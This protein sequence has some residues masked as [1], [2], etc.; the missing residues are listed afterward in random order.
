MTIK[1]DESVISIIDDIFDAAEFQLSDILPSEWAEQNRFM[2]SD[3]S[4]MEGMFSFDNSPYTRE[5]VDFY[6]PSNPF[7][8]LAIMKGAQVGFSTSVLENAIGWIISQQ[9]GNILFLVGHDDLVEKA[10]KKVD[11]ML[12][13]SGIRHLIHDTSGR[14]KKNKSGDKDR[15]K[16]FTGGFLTLGPTNH[17]TLR[18]VSIKYALIDD[19]EAMK[20]DT[21]ESGGTV[22]MIK[23]RL[24]SY[25]NSYK[26]T[27]LSTPE[28][29]ETSNIEPEYLKGD[30][31]KYFIPCPCCGESI[32]L[33]WE[34]DSEI[35]DGEK[36]GMYWELNENTQLVTDSVGYVCQKCDGFFTDRN[37]SE[38][39]LNGEWKATAI[40]TD[41]EYTSYHLSALMAPSYMFGWT[42]Y[43]K[44][45]LEANPPGQPRN[46]KLHQA[47]V[48]LVLGQTYEPQGESIDAKL[49]QKNIRPYSIGTAPEKQS[50]ADGNG[51]IVMITLGSDMNG[52][53]ENKKL[54][55]VDDARLDYEI[56][57][58]SETG[59]SYSISHGSIGTFQPAGIRIDSV[60]NHP[61]RVKWSY[62]PGSKHCVWDELDKILSTPI[63][64]DTGRRMS[65]FAVGCDTAPYTVYSYPY[66]ENS[67]FRIYGIKGDRLKD[68][69]IFIDAD[70][71]PFMISKEKADLWILNVNRYKDVLSTHIG[72]V[73][74]PHLTPKQPADFMN[75]PT[76][77]NGLYQEHNYFSHFESEHKIIDEKTSR[78]VWKK[79]TGNHQNHIFDCRIYAMAAKDIFVSELFKEMKIKN[80]SWSDYVKILLNK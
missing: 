62:Q 27:F 2:T 44:Q 33:E 30:Q 64:V 16:D 10:M 52:T 5:I 41:P 7:R 49:L 63:Q 58:W 48:N 6:S 46:E 28:V 73:W 72:L 50:I 11:N 66:I 51:K 56:I 67:R 80:G 61:D 70:H 9:P 74:N 59:A 35:K 36:A 79:I 38:L 76:P 14:A 26:L 15:S 68:S 23:Q 18:Q 3:V 34:V 47:F 12:D 40:P 22:P 4:N 69:G 37:K 42:H 24:A 77:N 78:F 19:F 45:Y 65:I 57:G 55:Y 31:R 53:I 71:K 32:T 60:H 8:V 17:K 13:Q 21:K 43:V 75:F 20:G 25:A 54:G 1:L 29:K 39:L